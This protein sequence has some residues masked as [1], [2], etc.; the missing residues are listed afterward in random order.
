M[1]YYAY[2]LR[3]YVRHS[4]NVVVSSNG[5]WSGKWQTLR[6]C[7][8]R[9]LQDQDVHYST[10]HIK[11][12][13]LCNNMSIYLLRYCTRSAGDQRHVMRMRLI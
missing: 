1:F 7:R 2:S 11:N 4:V 5:L 9:Q 13:E 6:E 12:S 10:V 8:G 3:I